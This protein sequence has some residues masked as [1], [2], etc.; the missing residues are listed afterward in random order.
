MTP[1]E[2]RVLDMLRSSPQYPDDLYPAVSPTGRF[3][4]ERDHGSAKGG[5]GRREYAANNYLGKL[6]K[7]GFVVRRSYHDTAPDAG[8]WRITQ[9][10]LD[11]LSKQEI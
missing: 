8:K 6:E 1:T 5:P 7:K 10:G 3:N 4:T 11:A 9:A 2:I